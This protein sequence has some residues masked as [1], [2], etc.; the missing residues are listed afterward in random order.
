VVAFLL[1]VGL[2]FSSFRVVGRSGFL[3]P[4]VS[5]RS[6]TSRGQPPFTMERGEAQRSQINHDLWR[7]VCQDTGIPLVL[8]GWEG[9][10]CTEVLQTLSDQALKHL[11]HTLP[12][13][14]HESAEHNDD[15][16][17]HSPNEDGD[18]PQPRGS[19]GPIVSFN[20]KID[21]NNS[22][23]QNLKE[24]AK[25]SLLHCGVQQPLCAKSTSQAIA[26][27]KEEY[28]QLERANRHYSN[29]L[30][31]VEAAEQLQLLYKPETQI[32]PEEKL[33]SLKERIAV[34][35]KEIESVKQLRRRVRTSTLTV[36]EKMSKLRACYQRT[37]SKLRER[38][39]ARHRGSEIQQSLC[40]KIR[41]AQVK[42]YHLKRTNIFND[43]FFIWHLGPFATINGNRLGRLPTSAGPQN[44]VDYPEINAAWGCAALLLHLIGAYHASKTPKGQVQV[45][46]GVRS[47]PLGSV[48]LTT[49]ALS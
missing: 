16:G 36:K 22:A 31:I 49:L 6:S 44:Q 12:K 17:E 29:Y 14:H 46:F 24:F 47:R 2:I 40:T 15:D 19:A 1:K 28:R 5:L 3:F 26:D 7:T 41:V 34:R 13:E 42:A 38:E 21:S 30:K 37:V 32:S 8:E 11:K 10:Q 20:Y 9:Q 27:L 45:H 43:S 48:L 23:F 33:V 35:R 18:E 4:A 39:T 25:F